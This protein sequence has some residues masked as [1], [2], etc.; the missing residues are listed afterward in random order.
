VALSS[1]GSSMTSPENSTGGFAVSSIA[2]KGAGCYME[3]RES[4]STV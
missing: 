4:H 3:P 1:E 2:K